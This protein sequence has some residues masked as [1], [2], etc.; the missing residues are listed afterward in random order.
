MAHR[1]DARRTPGDVN[2]SRERSGSFGGRLYAL[3][4]VYVNKRSVTYPRGRWISGA[5]ITLVAR[6]FIF[7]PPR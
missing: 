6:S 3:N 2:V 7:D 4:A 5:R 1:R